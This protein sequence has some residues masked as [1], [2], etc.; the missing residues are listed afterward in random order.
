MI[1]HQSVQPLNSLP[2]QGILK[3][4]EIEDELDHHHLH[5]NPVLDLDLNLVPIFKYSQICRVGS[6]DGLIC[7]WQYG[8]EADNTYICNPVTKEY[9][10][11]PRQQYYR[12]GPAIIA[13]G[14]GVGSQ[15]KEYKVVRTFQGDIPHIPNS[16]SRPSLLKAE[17]YTLGTGKWRTLGRVPY[18]F[19]GSDGPFLDGHVHW[20]VL[21]VDSPEK[22][23]SFNID[24]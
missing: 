21:D 12:Q 17:V 23:C 11:L 22:L 18:W 1:Y 24:K 10:I 20:I 9:M 16:V 14:F 2:T 7:I 5:H 15:T 13:Y 4:V 6:V 3:R 19:N 8:P